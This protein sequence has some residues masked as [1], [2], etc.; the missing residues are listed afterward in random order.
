[1]LFKKL[2][3]GQVWTNRGKNP[4]EELQFRNKI[5]EIKSGYV[6]YRWGFIE[7]KYNK[8]ADTLLRTNSCTIKQFKMMYNLLLKDVN[9]E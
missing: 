5:L 4:F 3:V 7:D 2:K 1:M 6:K 9:D 8:G